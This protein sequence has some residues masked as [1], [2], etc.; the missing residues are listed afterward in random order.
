MA[1]EGLQNQFET[2]PGVLDFTTYF[3][4][5]QAI[6]MVLAVWAGFFKSEWYRNHPNIWS[7]D[8]LLN[9]LMQ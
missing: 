9:I 4:G 6:L 7:G 3:S 8:R 2:F 1:P 5:F